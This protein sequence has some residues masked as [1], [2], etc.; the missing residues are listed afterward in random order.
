[1]LDPGTLRADAIE[2]RIQAR[3]PNLVLR[4]EFDALL[5]NLSALIGREVDGNLAFSEADA[6]L[7]ALGALRR[8]VFQFASD[9]NERGAFFSELA[10]TEFERMVIMKFLMFHRHNFTYL[11]Q[12]EPLR[13][14]LS[15]VK[16][17]EEFIE[18]NWDNPI[19]IPAM[20][21]LANVS[22]RSLF[23]QFKQDRGYTPADFA[24]RVRLNRAREM[25]EQPSDGASVTQIALK[26]GF[27]NL[28]HFA[29]DFRLSFGELPSETFR[30]SVRRRT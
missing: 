26:C 29:R 4:I 18:A 25:L 19:N 16:V 15:A 3:L 12:R 6:H 21:K 24:K 30:K 2:T 8:G 20:A 27:Q 23:R 5:R 10:A 14:T 22:A 9:F 1:M 17:V 13:S 7:P 11:L 28:G